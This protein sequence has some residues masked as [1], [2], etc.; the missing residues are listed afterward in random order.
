M[1][2]TTTK[3]PNTEK[4]AV[5]PDELNKKTLK[6]ISK[7]TP[8]GQAEKTN[9]RKSNRPPSNQAQK[10]AAIKQRL[11]DMNID[12]DSAENEIKQIRRE[13]ALTNPSFVANIGNPDKLPKDPEKV[14]INAIKGQAAR[15]PENKIKTLKI[16]QSL[17]HIEMTIVNYLNKQK[18]YTIH[19]QK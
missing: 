12:I 7:K 18:K 1:P 9:N 17:R 16:A 13:I 11:K 14:K 2:P 5:K 3:K 19:L 15:K 4:S 10:S 8:D 6:K